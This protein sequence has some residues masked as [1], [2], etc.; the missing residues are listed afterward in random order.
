VPL[1]ALM[2]LPKIEPLFVPFPEVL[3]CPLIVT[4]PEVLPEPTFA[5]FTAE[6]PDPEV[7]TPVF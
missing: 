4:F 7:R 2:M 3:P 6:H 1:T 5:L